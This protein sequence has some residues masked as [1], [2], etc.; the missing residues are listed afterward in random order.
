MVSISDKDKGN[1]RQV[2]EGKTAYARLVVTTQVAKRRQRRRQRRKEQN[3][4]H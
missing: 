2:T 3:I 1:E 4:S